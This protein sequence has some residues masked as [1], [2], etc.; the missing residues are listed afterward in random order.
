MSLSRCHRWHFC[1]CIINYW[2]RQ[3]VIIMYVFIKT[4]SLIEIQSFGDF[5]QDLNTELWRFW[6][7]SKYRALKILTNI[8]IRWNT[9]L[10]RF[11]PRLKQVQTQCVYTKSITHSPQ[12][13]SILN[14]GHYNYI[15]VLWSTIVCSPA[16][17]NKCLHLLR[18]PVRLTYQR[19]YKLPHFHLVV[20]L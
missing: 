6:P 7:R 11:W 12:Y 15:I 5:D 16:I 17:T 14:N 2:I 20:R 18:Q 10:W 3:Y 4:T 8:W 9:E 19:V 13:N 1:H